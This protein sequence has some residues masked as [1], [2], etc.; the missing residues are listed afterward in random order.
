MGGRERRR[1]VREK[2]RFRGSKGIRKRKERKEEAEERKKRG[3]E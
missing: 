2:G 1:K 3:G